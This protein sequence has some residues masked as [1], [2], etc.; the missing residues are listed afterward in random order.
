[1]NLHAASSKLFYKLLEAGLPLY[2]GF[3][4]E[5]RVYYWKK[6]T[7]FGDMLNEVFWKNCEGGFS[8][9]SPFFAEWICIGS[10][11]ERACVTKRRPNTKRPLHVWGT[12]FMNPPS[13]SPDVFARPLIIHALRGKL[14]RERC[15]KALGMDLSAIPLGDP[16]LLIPRLFP[17]AKAS[18]SQKI[19]IVA[20]QIDVGNEYFQRISVGE[21]PYTLIQL[22]QDP[23]KVVAEMADCGLILSSGLHPLIC[24]DALGIPNKHV[25]VSDRVAGG[26]YKFRDYDSAFTESQYEPVD[27]R[28]RSITPADIEQWR[29]EYRSRKEEAAD[30][31][32]RL[33]AALPPELKIAL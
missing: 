1:M 29:D 9:C 28:E 3:H 10:V 18:G 26:S 30:I 7:N 13:D 11:L 21:S 14:T 23:A 15:A 24:A 27:L 4:P 5:P 8:R 19:G 33:L 6:T 25:I 12:G 31:A 2:Q 32:D 22:N 20:H 16:G 17:E